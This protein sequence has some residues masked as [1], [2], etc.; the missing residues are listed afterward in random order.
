NCGLKVGSRPARVRY[1]SGTRGR[2]RP[3]PFCLAL[4]R[5]HAPARACCTDESETQFRQPDS[6]F[7]I[8]PACG[9][10]KLVDD[11]ANA[12]EHLIAASVTVSRDEPEVAV[13]QLD[14]AVAGRRKSSRWPITPELGWPSERNTQ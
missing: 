1:R 10:L 11:R 13:A 5:Q 4:W 3:A 6:D 2:R 8:Y 12:P 7:D 14:I 9:C